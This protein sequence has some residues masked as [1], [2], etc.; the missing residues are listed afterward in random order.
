MQLYRVTVKTLW[1]SPEGVIEIW[2]SVEGLSGLRAVAKHWLE[3]HA[4]C[5]Y[6]ISMKPSGWSISMFL[7][8]Q[9]HMWVEINHN[10]CFEHFL[11]TIMLAN[12]WVQDYSRCKTFLQQQKTFKLTTGIM[13]SP[14]S[15]KT[16]HVFNCHLL[17]QQNYENNPLC[18]PFW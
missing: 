10:K 8:L 11:I 14:Y 7:L 12:W 15:W 18:L 16:I 1:T 4:G 13:C 6:Q 2:Y 3:I 5:L 9:D 17:C